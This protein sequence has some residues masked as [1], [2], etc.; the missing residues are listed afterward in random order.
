MTL[1]RQC[2]AQAEDWCQFSCFPPPVLP[3]SAGNPWRWAEELATAP[4]RKPLYPRSS[5][6][7]WIIVDHFCI[8]FPSLSLWAGHWHTLFML[9]STLTCWGGQGLLLM[10]HWVFLSSFLGQIKL[11]NEEPY[12]GKANILLSQ[13]WLWIP[14]CSLDTILNSF[15]FEMHF[16]LLCT[17]QKD[18]NEFVPR[19]V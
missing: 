8:P 13:A 10:C 9:F 5:L 18:R 1:P 11:L 14:K 15:L 17:Q 16:N 4:K 6:P 19:C 2:M 3:R 7:C 12:F